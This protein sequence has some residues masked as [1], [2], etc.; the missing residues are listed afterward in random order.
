[1]TKTFKVKM[2]QKRR[3]PCNR[4]KQ[5]EPVGDAGSVV[6]RASLSKLR[7]AQLYKL[8]QLKNIPER[9]KARSKE[10]RVGLLA[11]ITTWAECV[12]V[13]ATIPP[14][15]ARN[16]QSSKCQAP[17][18]K[19]GFGVRLLEPAGSID[20]HEHV[21][22]A[23]V[24]TPAGSETKRQ[25]PN[26]AMGFHDLVRLY[27]RLGVRHVALES[28]AEYWL[29]VFW[30]LHDAGFDVL[31]ANPVQTKATQGSKTDWKDAL[32]LA[33]A[34]R[35]GRLKPSVLCTPEQYARRKL[36]RDAT[37]K[38]EQGAK[39][40][41]RM[42][43][44]FEMFDAPEWVKALHKSQR[45]LRVLG[46][47]LGLALVDDIQPLL[48][49]EYAGGKGQVKD[50]AVLLRM[51]AEMA[52]FLYR[53]GKVAGNRVRLAHH[54]EEYLA[55]HRMAAELRVEALKSVAGD[56]RVVEN[57]SLLAGMP[58]VGV[59]SALAAAVEIVD[60]RFFRRAKSMAKWAGLAPRVNQSGHKKR[61]TGHIYKGGNKWL[62]RTCWNVA[63]ESFAHAGNE[64]HPVGDCVSHLYKGGKKA[65]KVAVTAGARKF[66]TLAH[67]V[68]TERRPFSE[69]WPELAE[70]EA[71]ANRE[72][73]KKELAK[74]VKQ[75]SASDLLPLVLSALHRQVD[76]LSTADAAYAGEIASILGTA[77]VVESA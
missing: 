54:L 13:G 58:D 23:A 17:R 24:V 14:P 46:G 29:K 62:R 28:T 60:E 8:L 9:A 67:R 26:A 18:L 77:H 55:C 34:L 3:T 53:L 16:A 61:V 38:V 6:G 70:E 21:L 37:K 41:N 42:D 48:A 5:P 63:K 44:I 19:A 43:A 45:G 30:A 57:I 22:V 40:L 4:P 10:A 50:P 35:D 76:S 33:Y 31:V 71:D 39:A 72:R 52:V 66:V 12:S 15:G 51:A 75:A 32:R 65:Y 74:R 20:V 2:P 64:G 59:D 36:V 27:H 68:L 73:K 11:G 56:P 25:F 47:C 1:M 49:A 69:V 7:S